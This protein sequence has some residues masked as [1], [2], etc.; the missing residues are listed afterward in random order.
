MTTI[1]TRPLSRSEGDSSYR[2]SLGI[3]VAPDIRDSQ[4]WHTI[5]TRGIP[6]YDEWTHDIIT[7]GISAFALSYKHTE[8]DFGKL[9][10]GQAKELREVLGRLVGPGKSKAVLWVDSMYMMREGLGFQDFSSKWVKYGLMPYAQLP[11]IRLKE[12]WNRVHEASGKR[13]GWL[14]LE[15]T[16]G[17]N[18][19]GVHTVDGIE[20]GH[21][22]PM[23]VE[24]ALTGWLE[25]QEEFGFRP[26]D[27]NDVR[28]EID[29]K[30]RSAPRQFKCHGHGACI[31]YLIG[32]RADGCEGGAQECAELA[33]SIN[34]SYYEDKLILTSAGRI[35]E[36]VLKVD[37]AH[38]KLEKCEISRDELTEYTKILASRKYPFRNVRW[39]QLDRF[40]C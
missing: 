27:E 25:V 39:L 32:R 4:G 21:E 2:V 28:N 19:H 34:G 22:Q 23:S 7:P 10:D 3:F 37:A 33:K 31:G 15:L 16:L 9:S 24:H 17:R 18:N 5:I 13:S 6:H 26:E 11:V 38:G 14:W 20:K 29:T 12:D 30:G 36:Y 35:A 40:S 1:Q 8:H